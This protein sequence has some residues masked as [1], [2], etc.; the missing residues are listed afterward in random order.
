MSRRT[1]LILS[2][3]YT[4]IFVIMCTLAVIGPDHVATSWLGV[5]AGFYMC[6]FSLVDALF[7]DKKVS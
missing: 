7:K 6:S 1:A 5:L 2:W 3:S 4:L